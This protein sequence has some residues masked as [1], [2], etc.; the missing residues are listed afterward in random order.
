[1]AAIW[2]AERVRIRAGGM[3]LMSSAPR[4]SRSMARAFS[5]ALMPARLVASNFAR[6]SVW[7]VVLLWHWTHIWPIIWSDVAVAAGVIPRSTC[8]VGG[9]G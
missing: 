6:V 7:S 5:V 8:A 1:M 4:L 9:S 2:A 3:S